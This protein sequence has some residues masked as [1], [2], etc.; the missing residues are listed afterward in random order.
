MEKAREFQKKTPISVSLSTLNP[1]TGS[2][3]TGKL[4]KRRAHQTCLLRNLCAGQEETVRTRHRTTDWFKLE[5][6]VY[7]GCILSPSCLTYLQSTSC[8]MLGWMNHKLESRLENSIRYVDDTTLMAESEEELEN[9]LQYS[10]LENL[11]N[12]RA[13][14]ATVY[15][16]TESDMTEWLKLSL[17][18]WNGIYYSFNLKVIL[19]MVLPIPAYELSSGKCCLENFIKS[20]HSNSLLKILLLETYEHLWEKIK[21]LIFFFLTDAFNVYLDLC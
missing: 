9:V 12:R 20:R 4:F 1:L 11:M 17:T 8:K 13:R 16:V 21:L 18:L 5:K 10:C 19:L 6:G 7:Q 2:Q 15:Q 14:R 3:Q